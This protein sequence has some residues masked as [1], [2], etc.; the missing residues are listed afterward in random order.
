MQVQ[1]PCEQFGS[2]RSREIDGLIE[3]ATGKPCLGRQGG[4]C[5]LAPVVA[6]ADE[7]KVPRLRAV[8]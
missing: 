2:D 1:N 6:V 4:R 8:V 3:A 7:D 5:Q